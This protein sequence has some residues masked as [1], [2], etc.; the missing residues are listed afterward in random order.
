[1]H[2]QKLVHMTMMMRATATNIRRMDGQKDRRTDIQCFF[3]GHVHRVHV[4]ADSVDVIIGSEQA[5]SNQIMRRISKAYTRHASKA[6][7]TP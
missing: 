1:M 5:L 7:N 6:C 4:E 2:K 3:C